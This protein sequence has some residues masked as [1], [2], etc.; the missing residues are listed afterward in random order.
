MRISLNGDI[1]RILSL[2]EVEVYGNSFSFDSAFGD[3][4][5]IPPTNINKIAF[6]QD[7]DATIKSELS[8][9]QVVTNPTE[10]IKSIAWV[11]KNDV[12]DVNVQGSATVTRSE[13]GEY[14]GLRDPVDSNRMIFYNRGNI[15]SYDDPFE[16]VAIAIADNGLAICCFEHS[17]NSIVRVLKVGSVITEK[18]VKVGT[19]GFGR[20]LSITPDAKLMAV[21]DPV[22]GEVTL[23][24]LTTDGKIEPSN[25]DIDAFGKFQNSDFG[26]RV[27]L[28]TTG[29][30]LAVAAPTY[31]DG[32]AQIGAIIV[33]RQNPN[34]ASKWDQISEYIYGS[35][36]SL[37]LGLG[38]VGVDD[39]KGQLDAN[40]TAGDRVSF[41]YVITCQDRY[42][43]ARFRD[44]NA[45]N[46]ICECGKDRKS[47]NEWGGKSL[48]TETDTC[49]PCEDPEGTGDCKQS[50]DGP[51]A[52]PTSAAPT[53]SPTVDSA[54]PSF[55]PTFITASPSEAPSWAPGSLYDGDFCRGNNECKSGSCTASDP[56]RPEVTTCAALVSLEEFKFI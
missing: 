34:D 12:E 11:Q 43:T 52:T 48:Q 16:G 21:G 24:T 30:T 46:P 19:P 55:T 5:G 29:K 56:Q 25:T 38:G 8:S 22:L 13:N 27:G 37:K 9:F 41:K 7:A 18:D 2:A 15:L 47:S 26:H 4:F 39:F 45:F 51:T 20:G 44:G 53:A 3:L 33:Y 42:A 1:A 31:S 23:Y 28:S 14:I 32:I 40:D 10:A 54:A 36:N 50:A 6:V 17:T 49:I 35:Q